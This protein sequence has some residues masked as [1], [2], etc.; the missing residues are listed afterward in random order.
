LKKSVTSFTLL[1]FGRRR[2]PTRDG[3][4]VPRRRR[5]QSALKERTRASAIDAFVSATNT[6]DGVFRGDGLENKTPKGK[7]DDEGLGVVALR[8][9]AGGE[10]RSVVRGHRKRVGCVRGRVRGDA[11]RARRRRVRISRGT[12]FGEKG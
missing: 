1:Y 4:S 6:P 3:S 12:F 10:A 9:N 5:S 7:S 8:E 11:A 2:P